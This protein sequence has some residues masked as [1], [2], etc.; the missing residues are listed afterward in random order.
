[1]VNKTDLREQMVEAFN[2]ADYPVNS[3]IELLPALPDG[4]GT[5]F[6][7]GE[8]SMSVIKLNMELESDFPYESVDEI[9]DHIMEELE[10]NDKI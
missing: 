5:T 7:S 10:K 9:V 8:F 4:A 3:P 6:E 2:D 1:M